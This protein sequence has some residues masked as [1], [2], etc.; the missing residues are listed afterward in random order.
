MDAHN[1]KV[2]IPGDEELFSKRYYAIGTVA[3]MFGVNVSLIRFWENEF[4]ILKP[5]K[6]GKGD[7]LFRPE[8][9][10]N[11]QM[12]YFLLREKKYTIEGAKDFIRKNKKAEEQYALIESLQKLKFFLLELKANI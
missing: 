8:D 10:K 7:R 4:D 3:G 5:K 9:V 12:I 6:N 11:L 2:D 1:D